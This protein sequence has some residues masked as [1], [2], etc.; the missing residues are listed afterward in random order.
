MKLRL[1]NAAHSALAYLGL[2]AGHE[3]VADAVGDPALAAFALG[4]MQDAA[5]TLEL[6]AGADVA[7]YQ[8]A[9]LARFANPAL[10]HRLAQIAMDGSQKLPPRLIA[11]MEA[12]LARGLPVDRHAAAVAAWVRYAASTPGLADPHAEAIGQL[13]RA[14]GP[15]ALLGFGP[16]FGQCSP[17]LRRAVLEAL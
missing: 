13:A 3:T 5:E 15:A 14:G 1:L 17:A 9:L 16:M 7:A 8:R 11:P 2:A 4:L 10:R 6:P 12:R